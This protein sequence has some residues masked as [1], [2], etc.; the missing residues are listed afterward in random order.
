[1]S[2]SVASDS[3]TKA[4][5]TPSIRP[6]PY[7][8]GGPELFFLL[9]IGVLFGGIPA[10]VTWRKG[11]SWI[12]VLSTLL[13]GFIPYVGWVGAWVVA[14]RTRPSKKCPQCAEN[15]HRDAEVCRYCQHAFAP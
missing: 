3:F 2:R 1:M 6:V 12:R 11:G 14:M 13:F 8:L 5:F 15:V 9:V 4:D 10:I 7:N